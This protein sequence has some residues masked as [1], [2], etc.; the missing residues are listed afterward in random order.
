MNVGREAPTTM[1][2][3]IRI[4]V[5]RYLLNFC[6]NF[7]LKQFRVSM[8][9]ERGSS[10]RVSKGVVLHALP[11]G[12]ATAP[13]VSNSKLS[14]VLRGNRCSRISA[15]K[16][17]LVALSELVHQLMVKIIILLSYLRLYAFIIHLA[18]TLNWL[19]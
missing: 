16:F 18:R 14:R 10:P 9:A 19:A 7:P 3:P 2:R 13:L 11:D 15:A 17:G 4:T 5:R 8:I 1:A 12:R 6:T